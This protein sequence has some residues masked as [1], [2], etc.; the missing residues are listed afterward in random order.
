[1]TRFVRRFT[2][3]A[4]L[5]CAAAAA[6]AQEAPAPGAAISLRRAIE[7]ALQNSRD[8]RVAKLQAS[9]AD[10]S[11]LI[12]R[13]E[14]LPNIYAGSGL[15]YTK[16][17][18]ETPGGRAPSLFSV[19]YGEQLI[20]EPLRGQARELRQ[21]AQSQKI[22][23][24]EVRG[25]VILN[26]ALAYLDL[27]KVRHSLEL[28]RKGVESAEKILQITR[29]R[30]VEGFELPVETVKAQ[31]SRAKMAQ[32][33][34]HLETREEELEDYLRA[35][36]GLAPGARVEVAAEELP[37]EAEQ[38]G[39]D[40]IALAMQKN[41]E[42]RLAESEVRAKEFRLTGEKRGYFP[43]LELVSVY[44][45]LARFNFSEFFRR[46]QRQNFNVGMN[47]QV[48]LFSAR[49]RANVALAQA[50][51]DAARATFEN[52]KAELSDAVRQKTRRSREMDAA[53][54]VA[55][56]ELQLAQQ[57]VSVLQSQFA[58]GKVNLRELE[59]ARIQENDK[60]LAFLDATFLRQQAQ[61]DLLRV[62][63]QL[64]K[65]FQ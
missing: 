12:T 55:R 4:A 51:L 2:F 33:T 3:S 32:R 8:L 43:T 11:S 19:T 38:A 16:G 47:L 64:D 31:L 25:N 45:I 22:V 6:H 34:L 63:G 26:T 37:G 24:E 53:R 5:L 39:A 9:L 49:T 46:F 60:W 23:L 62:A 21:Q 65:V 18:P 44:S 36:F 52:K 7:L 54:E 50:G 35:Q 28:S 58:E 10:R 40:L 27:A 48:P 30:E 17:I 13:A 14:F 20:N 57:Q 15:G 61:L 41:T 42:V 1:M 59:Q 29:Q 56:L